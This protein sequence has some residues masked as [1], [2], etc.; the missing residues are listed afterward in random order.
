MTSTRNQEHLHD[1][2]Y[3]KSFALYDR[4]A[5][6]EFTGFFQARFNANNISASTT[7][8]G[9]RCLDAGCGNGRGSLFMLTNG[10]ASVDAIDIS[11]TNIDSTARNLHEFGFGGNY[12]CHIG[13]LEKLD[14]PDETFDFVWCNGVI[15]HTHNPDKCLQELSRVLRIGGKIWIYVYGSGGLY[16]YCVQR[17]RN[18][19]KDISPESCIAALRLMGYSSRYVAEYLDDWKVPYLRTYSSADFGRRLVECGFDSKPHLPFGV[20]YDTSH[21]LSI[22]P[23]DKIWLGEGDLRYL[24]TKVKP[25]SVEPTSHPISNDQFGSEYHFP[26]AITDRFDPLLLSLDKLLTSG[27]FNPIVTLAA[28]ARIQMILRGLMTE[29][30]AFPVD[31]VAVAIESTIQLL[32]NLHS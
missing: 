32:E 28:C 17:F 18:L 12:E 14:F 13:S 19:V 10:A 26:T 25:F 11:Q 24:A 20:S 1:E 23:N 15:M 8:K 22:Y 7:F 31:E 29:E 21:R 30:R 6:E 5:M 4:A 9:K 16:W 2:V 27:S 3:G